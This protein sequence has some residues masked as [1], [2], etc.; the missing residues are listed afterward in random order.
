VRESK[1]IVT[2]LSV[3]VIAI[4]TLVIAVTGLVNNVISNHYAL[5]SARAVLR[6]NSESILS[7]ID[8]LMMSRN[9]DGVLELLRDISYGSTTY[10]DIRLVSH[11]SGE[12]VV[13]HLAQTAS[14]LTEQDRS[15]AVCHDRSEPLVA[16]PSPLDDV[17]TDPAGTRA[18][19]VITPVM[20]QPACATADCHAHAESGPTLGFLHTE[21]SLRTVDT[22]LSDLNLSFVVAALV[23]ILLGT[24]GLSIMFNRTLAKPIRHMLFGIQSLAGNDLSFRFK[25]DR[26]DEFGVVEQSF[27]QMASR[28]QVQQTELRDAREYLE[29]IVENSADIIITVDPQGLIQT[30]NRGAEQVLDYHR[31]ELIGERIE[32]L[33]A[34]PRDRDVAI[35]QLEDRDHVSNYETR[36]LTKQKAVRHVLL[37]LS[38]LRDRDG[39][40]IGTIGISKDITTEKQ[41]QDLVVQ[42]QTAAAIG[43]AVT[44]IQHATKNMLNTLTGG[45]YLVRRGIANKNQERIEEGIQMV[46]EGI[47]T[48]GHLSL[49]M[50]KYAKKWTLELETVDLA[51]IVTEICKAIKQT[52]SEEDV[53]IQR[54]ISDGLPLVS[55]DSRLIH[56]ALLDMAINGMHAC[57]EKCY[58]APE[59]PE[60]LF[61]VYPKKGN[62][63]VVV[64]IQ[65]NGIGMSGETKA[66]IFKPFFTTKMESGTGLG[67]AL[68]SRIVELHGGAIEVE[69]EPDKGS[70]FRVALPVTG[71]HSNEGAKNG[72][73]SNN[74][75]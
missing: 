63:K 33:F 45:S 38:R 34:D 73:A 60:I 69:S 61:S 26:N 64:E 44:A 32:L 2:T 58:I 27:D 36:F 47:T 1:S 8:K 75:R 37:T 7:S 17:I 11:Y 29:G 54:N 16:S 55:C 21:Y 46:D 57:F 40:A 22:L 23:A 62:G 20:N 3:F 72:Q 53:A 68:A 15:C 41:L 51:L 39:V 49:N 66:D 14:I 67:L 9:N 25:T 5:E 31:D 74:H 13:S 59:A 18:L 24:I 30:V 52:A 19:R 10:R 6:F 4:V 35:A 65:D 48:I 43:Q 28:I 71:L 56:M 12:I 50:L 70:I 42:S